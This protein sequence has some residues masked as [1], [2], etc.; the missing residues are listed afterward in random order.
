MSNTKNTLLQ[1]AKA[2]A[3]ALLFSCIGVLLLALVAKLFGLSD[4]ILPVINQVLKVIAV[5]VAMILCLK[6]EKFVAKSLVGTVVFCL[7]SLLLFTLLGGKFSIGQ[8][9]LDVAIT[10]VASV[11]I[12][13][14][15][16]KRA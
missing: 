16:T 11:V 6:E 3:L 7:L 9:L 10:L 4:G 2:G 1:G 5:V 12:A 15:K 8:F 13:F 14:V